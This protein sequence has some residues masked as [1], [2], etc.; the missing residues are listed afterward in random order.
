VLSLL[1]PVRYERAYYQGCRCGR[2]WAPADAEL[3]LTQRLTPGA[4]EVTALHGALQP[5]D[6]AAA[7][8]LPKSAGLRVAASTVQRITE[9]TGEDLQRRRTA[10]ET[11][12]TR[13]DWDWHAD[14]QG[15]RCAYASLD[16]TGVRQQG[17][18][19]R[20]ADGRMTWVAELFNPSPAHAP[21]R[22]RVWD[23]RYLAGL[24]LREI[25][26]QLG[27]EARAVGIQRADILI[28]LTD[29][30]HG[31]EDCLLDEV[32]AGLGKPME[33]IL[34]FFHAA[35]H[36]HALAQELSGPGTPQAEAQAAAWCQTLKHQGGAVVLRDLEAVP[37]DE[38]PPAAR[39]SHR[40][41]CDYLRNNLHRTEYPRYIDNGWHIGSGAIESA[42]KNLINARLNGCGMRWSTHGTE[43]LSHLRALYKSEPSAWNDYWS[44]APTAQAA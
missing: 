37:L 6:E 32:F 25:G 4:A 33:F 40:R 39:E 19:G 5:F 12:G 1:G 18:G 34:D 11:F 21:K 30:G 2:G 22:G 38:R 24:G 9:Q 44:R 17:P 35:E 27:R 36:L 16:A 28:G 43:Q 13:N 15:R 7:K 8:S 23:A 3:G 14:A 29:G 41:L 26:R 42:C 31:L 20:Q 10:G